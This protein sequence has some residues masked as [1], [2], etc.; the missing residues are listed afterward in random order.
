MPLSENEIASTDC[1]TVHQEGDVISFYF[2]NVSGLRTNIQSLF[3]KSFALAYKI[4][5]FVKLGLMKITLMLN[6]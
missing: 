1:K 6:Y 4:I 2:Q 5:G 3:S